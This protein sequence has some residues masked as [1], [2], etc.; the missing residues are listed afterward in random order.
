MTGEKKKTSIE[1]GR[2]V[3]VSYSNHHSLG[4]A[5]VGKS[6]LL[7][8]VLGRRN[9]LR[10]S[11]KPVTSFLCILVSPGSVTDIDPTIHLYRDERRPSTSSVLVANQGDWSW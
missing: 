4:R 8:A 1:S 5:N 2:C 6:T 9:L 3:C 7:N 11:K 10:T